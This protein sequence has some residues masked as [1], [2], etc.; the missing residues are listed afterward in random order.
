MWR[1]AA[2][3]AVLVMVVA[4]GAAAG[5]DDPQGDPK[6]LPREAVA[7]QK[8]Y[9]KIVKKADDERETKVSAARAALVKRLKPLVTAETKRGNLKAALAVQQALDEAQSAD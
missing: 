9:L 6:D 1:R 5:D 4:L 8:E 2:G 7:A 3:T